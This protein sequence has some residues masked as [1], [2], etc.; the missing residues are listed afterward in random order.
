[1]SVASMAVACVIG[2]VLLAGCGSGSPT[3]PTSE[4]TAAVRPAVPDGWVTL[5]TEAGD[6]RVVV[7]PD[8]GL[9]HTAPGSVMGQPPMRDGVIPFEV[10]AISP[11]ELGRRGAGQSIAQWMEDQGLLPQAAEGVIRGPTTE[12]ELILPVGR[13]IEI[14]TSAQP[15]TPDEG[16]VV[17]YLIETADGPAVLR[18]VG[19]PAGVEARRADMALMSQLVEFGD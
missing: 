11:R 5:T 16:R 18:F 3:L 12:R 7:P 1:M 13:A 4:P 15:G 17:L 10:F 8:V 2:S 6:I 14:T 19:T 9:V